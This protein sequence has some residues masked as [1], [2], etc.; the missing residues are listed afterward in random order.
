MKRPK[1][2]MYVEIL[3]ILSRFGPLTQTNIV[4]KT[5]FNFNILEKHLTFLIK[6]E[7]VEEPTFE[8]KTSFAVTLKGITVLKFFRE[9]EQMEPIEE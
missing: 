3:K 2:E 6:Q 4:S 8:K 1:I 9:L 5:D 7:M